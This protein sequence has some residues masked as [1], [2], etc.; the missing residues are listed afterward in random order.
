MREP[1]TFRLYPEPG[2]RFVVVRV[3]P[4]KRAMAAH[5]KRRNHRPLGG[6]ASCTQVTATRYG[7][8]RPRRLGIVA[9]VNFHR[10]ALGMEIVTHEMFHATIAWGRRAGFDF[11]R[12]AV[13]YVNADEERLTY[14]HGRLCRDFV[15]RAEAAGLY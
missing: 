9:E 5:R 13:D 12:L 3:W 6:E 10:R 11:S 4:T 2:S 15:R 8:T 14:V 1:R 7:G